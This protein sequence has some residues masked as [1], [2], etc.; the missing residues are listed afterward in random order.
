MVL[1]ATTVENANEYKYLFTLLEELDIDI[2]E[3][4]CKELLW[5]VFYTVEFDLVPFERRY[6]SEVYNDHRKAVKDMIRFVKRYNYSEKL[7]QLKRVVRHR[8]SNH[9]QICHTYLGVFPTCQYIPKQHNVNLKD[10]DLADNLMKVITN[11]QQ[12][13]HKIGPKKV[14]I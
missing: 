14:I 2:F 11:M 12:R 13:Q 4:V 3:R 7:I 9:E 1:V 8:L 6:I 5:N 10:C